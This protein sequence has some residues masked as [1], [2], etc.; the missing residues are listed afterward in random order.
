MVTAGPF[1]KVS[2]VCVLCEWPEAMASF[3]RVGRSSL[4]L[5]CALPTGCCLTMNRAASLCGRLAFGGTLPD[6]A[7]I[8]AP[9]PRP[10]PLAQFHSAGSALP[11]P[12][13]ECGRAGSGRANR[14]PPPGVVGGRSCATC[15]GPPAASEGSRWRGWGGQPAGRSAKRH[16]VTG[17]FIHALGIPRRSALRFLPA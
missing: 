8:Y 2:H 11:T 10:C 12:G 9:D 6:R 13:H 7:V 5:H 16:L 3:I 14:G 4:G 1:G 17:P 15:H